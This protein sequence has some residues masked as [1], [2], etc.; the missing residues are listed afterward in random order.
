MLFILRGGL[1]ELIEF[2][3]II[4]EN[5]FSNLDFLYE[6]GFLMFLCMNFIG[7]WNVFINFLNVVMLVFCFCMFYNELMEE[8][9]YEIEVVLGLKNLCVLMFLVLLVLV[10]GFLLGKLFGFLNLVLVILVLKRLNVDWFNFFRD[11][12]VIF[13][14]RNVW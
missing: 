13:I 14:L 1:L 4:G 2:F 8:M 9:L 5:N 12:G 6:F 7:V 10:L 3:I 11:F